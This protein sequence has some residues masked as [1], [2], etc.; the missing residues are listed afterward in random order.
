M[1]TQQISPTKVSSTVLDQVLLVQLEAHIWSGRKKLQNTDLQ[2]VQSSDLP[3][4]DLASLGSKKIIDLEK[5]R[6]FEALKKKAHRVCENYGVRFLGGYAI[7][8]SK[9]QQVAADL[10]QIEIDFDAQKA[11]FVAQY[12][13]YVDDW[14]QS[15][16]AWKHV[17]QKDITP[18]GRVEAAFG[19]SWQAIQVKEPKGKDAKKLARGLQ[20]QICSLHEQLLKEISASAEEVLE[21]SLEGKDKA[22]QKVLHRIKQLRNKLSDLSFLNGSALPLVESID[23]TLGTLV[24][25]AGVIEGAAFSA[26]YQLVYILSDTSRAIA[27]AQ[28]I[29]G[30]T[31]VDVA[32]SNAAQ[33]RSNNQQQAT[34]AI[35]VPVQ[36]PQPQVSNNTPSPVQNVPQG[37]HEQGEEVPAVAHGTVTGLADM[38]NICLI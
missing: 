14:M 31:P 26:L 15:H 18:V 36:S 10:D 23:Y 19:F 11:A 7:P 25:A 13:Q 2:N 4:A 29:M 38:Q 35:S 24:P 33:L 27:H 20:T 12:Q 30:G 37:Q 21:K 34:I 1:T 16:P 17:L 5:L 22:T 9:V 8:L 6:V 3:P 28:I 32:M